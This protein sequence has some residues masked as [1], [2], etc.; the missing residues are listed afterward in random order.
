MGLRLIE[1]AILE[2]IRKRGPLQPHQVAD[3]LGLR[4]AARDTRQS[5]GITSAIMGA[6][7]MAGTLDREPHDKGKYFIPGNPVPTVA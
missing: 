1:H 7:V 6:M 4:R 2:T 5:A 3:A